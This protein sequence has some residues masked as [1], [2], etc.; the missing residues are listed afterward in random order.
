MHNESTTIETVESEPRQFIV[1]VAADCSRQTELDS[2]C[3]SVW[4]THA[5]RQVV[6]VSWTQT[7][8]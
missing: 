2:D 7:L 4:Q 3:Q 6:Q 1:G 8:F 5:D